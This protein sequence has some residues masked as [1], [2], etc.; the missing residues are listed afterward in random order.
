MKPLSSPILDEKLKEHV[1][2][3]YLSR[4]TTVSEEDAHILLENLDVR[5]FKKGDILLRE[6]QIS[7]WCYF[8]LKGCVRQYYLVD[9]E[10]KTT[11]FFTEGT[12]INLYEGFYKNAPAKYYL[13]CLEDSYLSVGPP[14]D[15]SHPL[16]TKFEPV[17]R[18]SSQEESSKYQ[19]MLAMYMIHSPEERYLNLL[20]T[21]PDLI[22]RVPQYYLASYLGVTP[23]TLSRI[24]KRIMSK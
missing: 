15:T 7:P 12:P 10:E 6:G 20:K 9:G 11:N 17:C 18:L 22:E 16:A 19:E 2:I 23:E 24:R 8:V 3:Q 13:V 1:L 5:S 14:E 21:R 4:F